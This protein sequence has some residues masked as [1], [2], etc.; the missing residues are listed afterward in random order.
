MG[1]KGTPMGSSVKKNFHIY[2]KFP[3]L[4]EVRK[5]EGSII[6]LAHHFEEVREFRG[7]S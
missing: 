4:K 3:I 7:I 5:T 1:S 2:Q 6:S